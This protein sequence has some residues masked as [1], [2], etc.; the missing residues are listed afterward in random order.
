[1]N[2]TEIFGDIRTE[3]ERNFALKELDLIQES[4]FKKN[5]KKA[6]AGIL[7][8]KTFHNIQKLTDKKD[9]ETIQEELSLV[10]KQ[11]KDAE[12]IDL[13]IAIEPTEEMVQTIY[14]W[15]KSNLNRKLIINF[16]ID[17]SVLGGAVVSYQGK[18]IDRSLRVKLDHCF[19][20]GLKGLT[21]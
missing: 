18:Y 16:K 11:I 13:T 21:G 20:N 15:I 17:P 9:V 6:L 3:E 10:Q 1:M 5:A 7:R 8:A 19:F 4:L 14:Q 2:Y 12:S